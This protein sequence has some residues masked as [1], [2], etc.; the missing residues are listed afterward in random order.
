MRSPIDRYQ[1][2]RVTNTIFTMRSSI[3]YN[4]VGNRLIAT[5]TVTLI[6]I[7]RNFYRSIVMWTHNTLNYYTHTHIRRYWN[8]NVN[9]FQFCRCFV[10]KKIDK[11]FCAQTKHNARADSNDSIWTVY[12]YVYKTRNLKR[13]WELCRTLIVKI[14][15]VSPKD[16]IHDLPNYERW[17]LTIRILLIRY[18]R[19]CLCRQ[20]GKSAGDRQCSEQWK[21]QHGLCS[22]HVRI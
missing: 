6:I 18:R 9:Y 8:N 4:N 15:G 5:T 13:F 12:R 2:T 11:D 3:I 1:S 19:R 21:A 10:R 20:P 7:E 16:T 22:I 17:T 14:H